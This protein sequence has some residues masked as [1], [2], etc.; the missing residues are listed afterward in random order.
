MDPKPAYGPRV[1]EALATVADAFRSIRR[2]QTDIPYLTHLLH[3]AAAV[4]ENGGDEDQFIAALLHDVLEDIPEASAKNLEER[5]G[6]R[7]ARLVEALSD[8]TAHPKPPWEE[9]KKAYLRHLRDAPA[10]V[11][12]ISACDKIH[13]ATRILHDFRIEGDAVFDRFKASKEQSLWY[14]REVTEALAHGWDHPL[15]QTLR[16]IVESL[17]RESGVDPE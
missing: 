1:D 8:T 4:W 2:K 13:N 16:S 10:E 3:V 7:V 6:A 5:F 17:H 11:K 12:L 9:R 14:Y 15:V